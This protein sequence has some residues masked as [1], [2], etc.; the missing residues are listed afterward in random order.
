MII[1]RLVWRMGCAVLFSAIGLMLLSSGLA[2][3]GNASALP[4]GPGFDLG[5][6]VTA[7]PYPNCRFGIGLGGQ[8]GYDVAPLNMGWYLDW[9]ATIAPARPNQSEYMQVV[10]LHP[11]IG[12]GFV[13]N[14]PT[15]TLQAAVFANPGATW[16]IGNEPDSPLQD[17]V[18]PESYAKAYYHLYHL[19][20]SY[21]PTAQISA[22]SIV[23]PTPLR[24]QYLD[25]VLAAYQTQYG[26]RMPTDSWNIHSYIL[27]EIT[28]QDP[29]AINN[30]GP[31]DV[32]GAFVPPGMTE[33]RGLLYSRS[34]MFSLLIFRQRLIDFRQWMARN[35]YRDTPLYI[36]EYG[37][38]FPYPPY[39]DPWFDEFGVE[40]TEARTASF[41]TDTFNSLLTLTDA[42]V[43]YWPDGNRLVQRWAWYSLTET[44]LGGNLFDPNTQVR[45]PLGD[46][47][48]AYTDQLSP[49]VD[50]LAQ[51]ESSAA[52]WQGQPLTFTLKAA[53]GNQGNIS[54]SVPFTV[55]FYAGLPGGG[56]PL[57]SVQVPGGALNGCGGVFTAGV[58]WVISSAGVHPFYVE[59]DAADNV[60]ETD[61]T[62]NVATGWVLASTYH[63]YL[64]VVTR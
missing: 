20:K 3:R 9:Q 19:I 37:T 8:A 48:A 11:T 56:S 31:Y 1:K 4:A 45:R 39:D 24:F 26:Q 35:G 6:R 28:V 49:A 61:E 58:P 50:L 59:V 5:L 29:E 54:V 36:T 64:P 7:Q 33:T 16:L 12:G 42:A 51:A 25:R 21:D 30:G 53:L 23:Q 15:A 32:W 17:N 47:F 14:P 52:P 43:G 18:V 10:R 41:M 2:A 62:N 46:V 38:L 57:G 27:R 63:V 22:G 60:I 55:T 44:R 13:F 40:L 34:D